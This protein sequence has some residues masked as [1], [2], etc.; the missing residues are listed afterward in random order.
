MVM[1]LVCNDHQR[2]AKKRKFFFRN[3][4]TVELLILFVPNSILQS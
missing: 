2:L 3:D 4:F 1:K